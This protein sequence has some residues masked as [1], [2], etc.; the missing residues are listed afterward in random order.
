MRGLYRVGG[1]VFSWLSIAG[2]AY[3]AQNIVTGTDSGPIAFVKR[4]DTPSLMETAAFFPFSAFMGGARVAFNDVTGDAV[5]DI[6]VGTGPGAPCQVRVFDGVTLGVVRDFLPYG[7][8]FTGGV[9]VAAADFNADGRPTS[10][11]GP[12]AASRPT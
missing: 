2:P 6:V 5:D 12:T 11:P 1:L 7:A 8:G 9:F 4:F 10:S 3:S